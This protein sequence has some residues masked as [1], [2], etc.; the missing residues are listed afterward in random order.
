MNTCFIIYLKFHRW[1]YDFSSIL[2]IFRL[3]F[4]KTE[5]IN[6]LL[7]IF[8]LRYFFNY[9]FP[10]NYYKMKLNVFYD[11]KITRQKITECFELDED[12]DTT[13]LKIDLLKFYLKKV[14]PY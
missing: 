12:D 2:T 9:F 6:Y 1:I 3:H 13:E 10:I 7:K 11:N 8:F 4:I 14:C 5:K